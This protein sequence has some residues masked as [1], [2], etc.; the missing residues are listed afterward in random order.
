L[1]TEFSRIPL[2]EKRRRVWSGIGDNSG[3]WGLGPRRNS[4][5]FRSGERVCLVGAELVTIPLE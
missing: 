3:G 1:E 5:E 4:Y 2:R